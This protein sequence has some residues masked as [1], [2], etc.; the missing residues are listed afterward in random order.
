M[1]ETEIKAKNAIRR[2]QLNGTRICNNFAVVQRRC[3]VFLS[4]AALEI[5]VRRQGRNEY[6]HMTRESE[7]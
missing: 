7:L 5:T 2:W 6:Y 1:E 3:L 4:S